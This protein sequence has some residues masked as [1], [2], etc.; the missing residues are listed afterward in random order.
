MPGPSASVLLLAEGDASEEDMLADMK[1]GVVV[2]H[3]LGAGQSNVQGGEFS[4][5]ILLGY[6]VEKGKIE[7]RVKNTII[8]GNVYTALSQ[9]RAQGKNS[10]WVGGS[11]RTPALCCGGVSVA[12]KD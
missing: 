2:E 11:I 4:A 1:R 9:I 8:S 12:T 5:N 3:L 6:L 10:R 7:G